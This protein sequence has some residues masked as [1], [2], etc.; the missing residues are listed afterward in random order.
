M[1]VCC[2]FCARGSHRK[3]PEWHQE[4]TLQF[5]VTAPSLQLLHIIYVLCSRR[6]VIVGDHIVFLV[7]CC[8][9]RVNT[10]LPYY[11][12]GQSK[13]ILGPEAAVG[14]QTPS[15][16]EPPPPNHTH[17]YKSGSICQQ[18]GL[19]ISFQSALLSVLFAVDL[20]K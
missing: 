9:M 19:C 11:S 10:D 6:L 4:E 18:T 1:W 5:N 13:S 15:L 17:T 12:L 7:Q 3:K 8:T 20:H 14:S 2:N 16:Y